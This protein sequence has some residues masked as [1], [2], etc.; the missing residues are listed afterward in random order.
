MRQN[1]ARESIVVLLS[2]NLESKRKQMK[3]SRQK[4]V[5]PIARQRHIKGAWRKGAYYTLQKEGFALLRS[6][7]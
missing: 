7:I 6:E 1:T 2:N 3:T 4:T 5:G